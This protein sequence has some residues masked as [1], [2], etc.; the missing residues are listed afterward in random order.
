MDSRRFDDLARGLA[1]TTS[2]RQVLKLLAGSLLSAAA[3][4]PHVPKRAPGA[5]AQ[6]PA[7]SAF[8]R[9]W[10][11]TDRPVADGHVSRTWMWGPEPFTDLVTEEYEE[12]PGGH[13]TV[14]YFDKSRMEITDP[15]GDPESIWYVTNGL[16]S[17]ELI[18]GRMQTGHNSFEQRSPAEINVAG[19]A[20]ASVGPTYATFLGLLDEEAAVEGS[21]IS[22]R[23]YRDGTVSQ[24]PGLTAHNVVAGP[25]DDV[26]HHAIALP[27]WDF[28]NSVGSIWE[29]GA[30][31]NDRLF[32]DPLFPTGRPI[33][34]PYWSAIQV[35]GTE[36]DVLI[37]C[38]ERRC[39]THTPGNPPG[40]QT[41]AGNVGRHYHAWRYEHFGGCPPDLV[42]PDGSCLQPGGECPLPG[43][44]PANRTSCGDGN[45][46]PGGTPECCYSNAGEWAGCCPGGPFPCCPTDFGA[47]CATPSICLIIQAMGNEI[48]ALQGLDFTPATF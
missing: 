7:N 21:L 13:R 19:D 34:E 27:F 42:C 8:L 3:L 20:D 15:A 14:Q 33:T 35:G 24:D 9:T 48:A 2:R 46:C 11:R 22:Q 41:E 1:A 26:T 31:I 39:L 17:T 5:S 43:D 16:L 44:C 30:I 38:F 10:E 32:Q 40:W 45:C 12:S 4:N 23:A 29:D 47:A 6:A 25:V 37:Q 36:Q 18:S 28:M